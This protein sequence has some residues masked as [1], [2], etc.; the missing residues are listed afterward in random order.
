MLG[1]LNN[2]I[3][4]LNYYLYVHASKCSNKSITILKFIYDTDEL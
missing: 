3:D 4:F 1:F 2:L